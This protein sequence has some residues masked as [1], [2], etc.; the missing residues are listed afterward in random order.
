MTSGAGD[1][2]APTRPSRVRLIAEAVVVAVL[3]VVVTKIVARVVG[4][5]VSSA[6]LGGVAAG[7]TTVWLSRRARSGRSR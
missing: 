3:S 6:V 1:D 7:V 5:D 2:K 4:G